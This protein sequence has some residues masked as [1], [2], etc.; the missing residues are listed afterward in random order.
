MNDNQNNYSWREWSKYV[1][2]TLERFEKLIESLRNEVS[3]LKEQIKTIK[4]DIE[5]LQED[6]ANKLDLSLINY[7]VAI[8]T[9]IITFVAT[10]IGAYVFNILTG[11]VI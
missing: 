4:S 3:Y 8:I 10:L 11:K 7:K 1:L 5:S 9:G 2:L 6:K